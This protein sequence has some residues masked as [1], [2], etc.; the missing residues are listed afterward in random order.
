MNE[1]IRQKEKSGCLSGK[2]DTQLH[3]M[4]GLIKVYQVGGGSI[5]D[6]EVDDSVY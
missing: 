6:E 4:V 3:N 1:G 5:Q 2:V